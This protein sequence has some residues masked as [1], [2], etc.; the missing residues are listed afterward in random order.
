MARLTLKDRRTLRK[1]YD[2][3]ERTVVM[4]VKLG[5]SPTAIYNEL[6]RG[7]DGEDENGKPIYNPDLAQKIVNQNVTRC[8]NRKRRTLV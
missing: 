1:M 2:E 3:D 8:G 6:K 5:C 4:A 7:Y